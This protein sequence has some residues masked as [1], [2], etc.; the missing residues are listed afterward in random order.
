[1]KHENGKFS[2][3]REKNVLRYT[4]NAPARQV[5]NHR[6]ATEDEIVEYV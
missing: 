2:S 5:G 4:V 3:S 1:M 6:Q